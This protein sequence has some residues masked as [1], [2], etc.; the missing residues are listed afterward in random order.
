VTIDSYIEA[1]PE[2]IRPILAKIRQAIR[3]AAPEA[4][5]RIAWGMPT[6]WQGE[7]L[8]HFAAAKH[9]IGIYP[10]E[11]SRLPFGDKLEGYRT[12]KG[13]IQFPLDKPIDY[14]FIAEITRCRVAAVTREKE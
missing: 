12:S 5:E 11:V 8:I 7:N 13:A 3:G 6:Y 4:A 1:Q 2:A 9:H 10:G 14:D